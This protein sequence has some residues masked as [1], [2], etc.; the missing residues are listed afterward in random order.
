MAKSKNEK[1][2]EL[3]FEKYE[4]LQRIN[5]HGVFE[6]TSTQINEF[7]EARLMTKFDHGSQLPLIFSE[8]GLSILPISR[9]SYL[10]ANFEI[11]KDFGE[12]LLTTET[13]DFRNDL[14]SV[15][16]NNITSEAIALNCAYNSGILQDFLDDGLL[17]ATVNGRMSS[18]VFSFSINLRDTTYDVKVENS[19]IEIDAG[20]EGQTSLC[21]IEAKNS[22][23]KDFLIRQLYYPFRLWESKIGKKVRPIFMTYSNGV[24]HFREY[25][26]EN[27]NHYNSIKLIR[28]KKYIINLEV[29]GE[30]VLNIEV[31]Q[32]IQSD[33]PGRI[34]PKIPF[35]QADSFERVINLL[36]L[37]NSNGNLTKDDL[38]SNYDF[39]MRDSID[40]RQIDYYVN[41]GRYLGLVDKK[42]VGGVVNYLLSTEGHEL[43]TLSLAER[44]KRF[45]E[46][47]LSHQ[48]FNK[49]LDLY[50]SNGE[51]PSRKEIVEVMKRSQLY[52]IGGE[53]TFKRR[54][55]TVFSWVNWILEQIEE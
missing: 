55:S 40:L 3:L 28:E 10:I 41:A 23:S 5:T 43:F 6:I 14:E 39:T 54:A 33:I 17:K 31:I 9:G 48:V 1:A 38:H 52:N 8:N 13:F 2:W 24:Y 4:I 11:F 53:S 32:S 7:R 19:Q 18:A 44:Q 30:D 36:E 15:D 35:P 20:F 37:L 26:F 42:V 51:A 50:F 16:Y 22:L 46:T 47:I 49:T 21:L 27:V 25:V 45:I 12:S 29:M 34:E